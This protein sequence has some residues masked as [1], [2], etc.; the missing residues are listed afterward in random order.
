[1]S[2]GAAFPMQF[3]APTSRSISQSREL[4]VSWLGF[5]WGQRSP[6]LWLWA[7]DK[8]EAERGGGGRPSLR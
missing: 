5:P 6:S 2:I 3:T 1:M 7:A 4:I 8:T